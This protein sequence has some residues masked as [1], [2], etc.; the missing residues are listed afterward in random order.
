MV[1]FERGMGM[2]NTKSFWV[3]VQILS[4][5]L[6][7]VTVNVARG[8]E[9][10]TGEV[11]GER[12]TLTCTLFKNAKDKLKKLAMSEDELDM[13]LTIM[14]NEEDL[15]E[16]DKLLDV[17]RTALS[18]IDNRKQG[19]GPPYKLSNEDLSRSLEWSAEIQDL[20]KERLIII[21]KHSDIKNQL[22]TEC[23]K[24]SPDL[25]GNME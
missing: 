18:V 6:N 17:Y 22:L 5:V 25:S 19:K 4:L 16:L 21:N 13:L 24:P 8:A 9:D 11:M 1:L 7:L 20:E 14:D 3:F 12:E 23:G 15:K 10:R 2:K